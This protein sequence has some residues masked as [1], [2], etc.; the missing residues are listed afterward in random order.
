MAPKGA[1]TTIA[2]PVDGG[3]EVTVAHDP[4]RIDDETVRALADGFERVLRQA[5]ADPAA[6]LAQAVGPDVLSQVT[7]P[8]PT[9]GEPRPE[10]KAEPSAVAAPDAARAPATPTQ[11]R[12]AELWRELL[13][14][15]PDAAP[16][17]HANF[18]DLGGD[19]I[20]LTQLL[21]WVMDVF[22]IDLPVRRIHELLDI[23]SLASA[24]DD[25]VRRRDEE[26]D[27]ALAALVREVEELP[28]EELRKR[29]R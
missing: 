15:P 9:V 10:P 27:A 25:A 14:L 13:S 7:D 24:V 2:T 16:D 21:A 26:A 23:A 22:G 4:A 8:T 12:L 29:L 6:T 17:I 11:H 3:Y 18:F 28:E 1:L 5:V 19:S 20:K